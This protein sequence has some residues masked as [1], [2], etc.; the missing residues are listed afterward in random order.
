MLASDT[1]WQVEAINNKRWN[2]AQQQC[3]AVSDMTR[4][5]DTRFVRANSDAHV[6]TRKQSC[7]QLWIKYLYV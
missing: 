4:D 7:G 1:H 2:P 6:L 5:H 3:V